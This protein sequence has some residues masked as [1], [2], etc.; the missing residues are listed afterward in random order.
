MRLLDVAPSLGIRLDDAPFGLEQDFPENGVWLADDDG[1]G[2]VHPEEDLYYGWVSELEAFAA[3][4]R[5]GRFEFSPR[6]F[7]ESYLR[8]G[9]QRMAAKGRN[10]GLGVLLVDKTM[11]EIGRFYVR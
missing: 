5:A 4:N 10:V 3:I 6:Y 11:R 7:E 9:L 1:M 8:E 2:W